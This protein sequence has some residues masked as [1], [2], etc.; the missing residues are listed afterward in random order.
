MQDFSIDDVRFQRTAEHACWIV[1]HGQTVG[2]VQLV[3]ITA[4]AATPDDYQYRI[5]L[6][7]AGDEPC[8]VCRRSQVRLAIADRVWENGLVPQP[9]PA[10]LAA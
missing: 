3:P 9:L 4:D 10:G 5:E 8:F 6:Y 2:D 7:A 1:I